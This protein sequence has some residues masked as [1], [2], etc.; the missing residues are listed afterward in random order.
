MAKSLRTETIYRNPG[1][2]CKKCGGSKFTPQKVETYR[3]EWVTKGHPCFF[4][5]S[6]VVE[7]SNCEGCGSVDDPEWMGNSNQET[8]RIVARTERW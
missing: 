6:S 1:W 8:L 4:E 7:R 2:V 5:N 3:S